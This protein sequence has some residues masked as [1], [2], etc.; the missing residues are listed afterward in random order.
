MSAPVE[1]QLFRAAMAQL[2][3]AVNIVTT[4]GPAGRYGI[5]VSAVCSVSDTPASLLVCVNQ[6]SRMR[7][8]VQANGALVVNVLTPA[9]RDLCTRFATPGLGVAERFGASDWQAMANGAPGLEGA[10]VR[11]ACRLVQVCEVGTHAVIMAEVEEIILGA[12]GE[13]AVE[14]LV[15]F[16]RAFHKVPLRAG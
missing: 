6:A 11:L 12:G 15:Y 10:L 2:A 1:P 4:D 16:D 7:A 5:T 3:A 9:H 8:L 13:G 14:G